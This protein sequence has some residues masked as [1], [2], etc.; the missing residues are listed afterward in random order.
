MSEKTSINEIID[1]YQD[2]I[3]KINDGILASE[4]HPIRQVYID[5]ACIKDTRMGL[6]LHLASPDTFVYIKDG[7]ER[8]NKRPNRSF[9]FAY[10]DLPYTEEEL[11]KKYRDPELSSEIFNKSPDT[12]LFYNFSRLLVQVLFQ[13]GKAGHT[14]TVP[15]NIN[16]W[17]LRK[18]D[19]TDLF[20]N[21]L[22]RQ[23]DPKEF[24]IKLISVDPKN[25]K[26]HF[27]T[28]QDYLIID[29]LQRLCQPTS[30]LYK[31]LLEDQKCLHKDI[32]AAHCL[33]DKELEI[34]KSEGVDFSDEEKVNQRFEMTALYFSICCR[35]KF[36]RFQIPLPQK[37]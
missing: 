23:F 34:W 17:P 14:K 1:K 15:I 26:E 25:I 32:F 22:R 11:Q 21:I 20:A 16:I 3:G 8:Y 36:M 29:D 10:P 35:F 33:G 4:F 19:L 12:D 37:K 9:T 24:A 30:G 7:L 2:S 6:L 5:L 13:N 31:L 18:N 28:Q 27:W